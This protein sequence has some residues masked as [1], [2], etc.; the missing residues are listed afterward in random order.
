MIDQRSVATLLGPD[1]E[2]RL[3]ASA[4][5]VER[6]LRRHLVERVEERVIEQG[7]R[8]ETTLSLGPLFLFLLVRLGKIRQIFMYFGWNK[9]KY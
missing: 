9:K 1:V 5:D 3:G 2:R 6:R 7:L 4:P 8:R